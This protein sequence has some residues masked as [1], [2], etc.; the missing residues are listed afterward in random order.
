M[1]DSPY[2]RDE[3]NLRKHCFKKN[4]FQDTY[5]LKSINGLIVS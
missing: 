3:H 4:I 2:A 1:C 5:V